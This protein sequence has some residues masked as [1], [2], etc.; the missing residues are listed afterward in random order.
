M[1]ALHSEHIF[2]G[3]TSELDLV[4]ARTIE[5]INVEKSISVTS[6]ERAQCEKQSYFQVRANRVSKTDDDM[7]ALERMNARPTWQTLQLSEE[8]MKRLRQVRTQPEETVESPMDTIEES[9]D[10][11][12]H[13]VDTVSA[14]QIGHKTSGTEVRRSSKK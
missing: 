3:I 7:S 8:T 11:H 13:R 12:L 10:H 4:I 1:H 6:G 5:K 9:P 2:V 14:R